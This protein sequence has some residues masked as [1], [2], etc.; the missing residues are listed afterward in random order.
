MAYW[1]ENDGENIGNWLLWRPSSSMRLPQALWRSS[2][3]MI[4]LHKW[5]VASF[6]VLPTEVMTSNWDTW[7]VRDTLHGTAIA[8]SC[9]EGATP[10]PP[11]LLLSPYDS[12]SSKRE[13]LTCLTRLHRDHG[14]KRLWPSRNVLEENQAT[15][16]TSRRFRRAIF[17][18][19]LMIC[20]N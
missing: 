14:R 16:L 13:E 6:L 11:H 9:T 18:L 10:P 7:N 12:R 17:A 19:H 8:P 4:L 3:V 2:Q 1:E 5:E 20:L 15:I